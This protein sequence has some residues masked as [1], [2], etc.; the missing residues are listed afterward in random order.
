MSQPDD[1][2]PNRGRPV[3]RRLDNTEGGNIHYEE[4]DILASRGE[5]WMFCGEY[6]GSKEACADHAKD[7]H[8]E[9]VFKVFP[10]GSWPGGYLRD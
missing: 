7:Q 3:L 8:G 6:E 10:S 9:G 5:L 1:T 2:Q 4:W